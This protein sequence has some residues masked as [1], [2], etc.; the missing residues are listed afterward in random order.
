[1]N[2][3]NFTPF[4]KLAT[5]RLTLR[6][7]N[8][9]DEKEI[10]VHRSDERILKYIDIPKAETIEDARN[11]IEKINKGIDENEWVYWEITF[12]NDSQLIG[13]ICL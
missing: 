7:L 12:K 10:F 5:K 1:M 6:Q 13:T 4:P 11:F 2:T 9:E 3:I 8:M